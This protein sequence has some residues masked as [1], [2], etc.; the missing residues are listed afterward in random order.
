MYHVVKSEHESWKSVND[1]CEQVLG[2][3]V[4]LTVNQRLARHRSRRYQLWQQ[5]QGVFWWE[6]P[7][8]LPFRSWLK[9]LH[10]QFLTAGLSEHCLYP[11]LLQQRAWQRIIDDDDSVTLLDTEAAAAGARRAWD[12]ANAWDCQPGD[13]DYL[14]T[15][16][17][18]WKRWKGSYTNLLADQNAVDE[19]SLA[20]HLGDIIGNPDNTP[21]LPK[22][23]LLDGFLQLPPQLQQ[24][25]A[26]LSD[27]GVEVEII[28]ANPEAFVHSCSFK[29][30]SQE[31]LSIANFMRRELERDSTRSLGLVVPELQN[32]RAEVL[33]S[34]DTIFF[35]ALSPS[36]IRE[37][38]RPYDLS[39]GSALSDTAPV[40]AALL[41]LKLCVSHVHANDISA[42]LLSP[43]FLGTSLNEHRREQLDKKLRELRVRSLPSVQNP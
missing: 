38:G 30:D 29:D 11:E 33:R 39:I 10:N 6:T 36:E 25:V 15:D 41:M 23:I 3:A 12:V 2:G 37:H 42:V 8:I 20:D 14:P 43:Y 24:F 9:Q 31:L 7:D 5:E 28:I 26:V 4:L 27:A 16:Q 34:F 1:L 35:P 21:E 19:A 32:K 13:D 22:K 17:F 40:H 18:V